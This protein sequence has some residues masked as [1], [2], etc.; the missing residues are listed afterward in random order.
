MQCRALFIQDMAGLCPLIGMHLKHCERKR[1]ILQ[2][3]V[4]SLSRS[5]SLRLMKMSLTQWAVFLVSCSAL[6]KMVKTHKDQ[7]RGNSNTSHWWLLWVPAGTEVECRSRCRNVDVIV[8]V[9]HFADWQLLSVVDDVFRL[10]GVYQGY[11]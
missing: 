2:G 5:L 1:D 3:G 6:R 8:I 11:V 7:G 4:L 10:A 9:S